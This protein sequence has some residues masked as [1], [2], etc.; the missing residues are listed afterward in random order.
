MESSLTAGMATMAL[1][2]ERRP[3][4]DEE[5]S[6]PSFLAGIEGEEVALADQRY[7][8]ASMVEW[9]NTRY[10]RCCGRSKGRG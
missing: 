6:R 1:G 4:N 9:T 3:P 8:G 2:I 10:A 5:H 7:S